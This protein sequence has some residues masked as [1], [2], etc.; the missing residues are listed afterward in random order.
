MELNKLH[1]GCGKAYIEGWTNV[2]LFSN[3]KADIYADIQALPLPRN[4]FHLIYASHVLEHVQRHT[5]IATL[6]HWKDLLVSGG[7]LRLAVPNFDAVVD[8]YCNEANLDEVMGLLYGGQNHPKNYHFITFN[9]RTLHRDLKR[10]GFG[11]VRNWDWRTTEHRN[12]DDFSQ[13][14]LPHMEKETGTLMSLNM[15]AVKP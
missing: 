5:V 4:H 1:L 9:E 14:Y 6:T 7:V 8:R 12:V 2:D 15:E 13:C 11:D 3:V 10:A